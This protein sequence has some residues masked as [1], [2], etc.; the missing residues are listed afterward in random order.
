MLKKNVRIQLFDKEGLVSDR[1]VTQATEFY[2]GPKELHEGQFRIEF[3]ITEKKDA[4][5]AISYLK[6]LIGDLPI[7]TVKGKQG[8]K[9]STSTNDDDDFSTDKNVVIQNIL[10][11][12]K[13]NQDNLIKALRAIGFKFLTSD[14]L[15]MYLPDTYKVSE[16]HL[17]KYDWLVR[18]IKLAKDPRNDRYDPQIL[19]GLKISEGRDEKI[20]VYTYGE[21]KLRMS[22]PLPKKKM[23]TL[24]KTNLIKFPTYMNEE[25]RLKWGIE[26]RSLRTN[27]AKKPSKF[28]M[29]W[30]KDVTVGDELKITEEELYQRS[31][32]NEKE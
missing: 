32:P 11:E 19:V 6:K 2:M 12:N 8:R 22:I 31:N 13:D 7:K 26:H 21:K 4:E 24:A 27:P 30:F 5:D 9:S 28:Y 10:D 14:H 15:K 1:M 17:S 25:E 29:R 18:R 3:T 16:L 20:V 23:I